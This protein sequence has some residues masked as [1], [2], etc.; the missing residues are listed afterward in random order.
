MSARHAFDRLEG[1]EVDVAR[2]WLKHDGHGPVSEPRE[3]PGVRAR[4]VAH[5]GERRARC[6]SQLPAPLALVRVEATRRAA[7]VERGAIGVLAPRALK[8]RIVPV[9]KPGSRA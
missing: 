6:R 2:S 8:V 5:V 7:I 9:G 3:L 1:E 4:A